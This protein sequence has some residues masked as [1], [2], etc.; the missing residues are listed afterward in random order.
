V[1]GGTLQRILP[2]GASQARLDCIV[3]Q[4]DGMGRLRLDYRMSDFIEYSRG[5]AENGNRGRI[6]ALMLPGSQAYSLRIASRHQPKLNVFLS[7]L[8]IIDFY[9]N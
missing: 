9:Q 4:C 5:G 8:N 7:G 2:S 3:I 6:D 1:E